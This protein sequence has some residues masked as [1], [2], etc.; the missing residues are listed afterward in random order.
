MSI[1]K[2]LK[3]DYNLNMPLLFD[4]N[5]YFHLALEMVSAIR[6]MTD[7]P[8]KSLFRNDK[9]ELNWVFLLKSVKEVSLTSAVVPNLPVGR[10]P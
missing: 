6:K 8:V 4:L 10:F 5:K 7:V 3:N 2:N 9:T 1:C